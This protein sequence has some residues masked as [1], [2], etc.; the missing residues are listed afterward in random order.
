[1]NTTEREN[2]INRLREKL[3]RGTVIYTLLR[4]I[5]TSGLTHWLDLYHVSDNTLLRITWTVAQATGANYSRKHEAVRESG[6]GMDMGHA[7][8]HYLS[9]ILYGDEHALKQKWL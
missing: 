4:H 8:V 6:T 7:A 5:S 3:P 2:A 9:H 1:M